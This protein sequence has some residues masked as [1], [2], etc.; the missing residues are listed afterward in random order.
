[1]SFPVSIPPIL[2]EEERAIL[3]LFDYLLDH[4]AALPVLEAL[5][6]M[7]IHAPRDH[8]TLARVL[9]TYGKHPDLGL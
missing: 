6:E 2:T 7:R 8:E 4:G 1:M 5:N 9:A 3:R